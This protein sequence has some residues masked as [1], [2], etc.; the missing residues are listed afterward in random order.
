MAYDPETYIGKVI[1]VRSWTT[2][3]YTKSKINLVSYKS[4][5]KQWTTYAEYG[6]IENKI[7]GKQ[8][9]VPGYPRV[10]LSTIADLVD[11]IYTITYP[12]KDSWCY[13]ET[14]VSV[15]ACEP[16]TDTSSMLFNP[17]TS[18]VSNTSAID[19]ISSDYRYDAGTCFSCPNIADTTL[20]QTSN[21]IKLIDPFVSAKS[22]TL[23]LTWDHIFGKDSVWGGNVTYKY[24]LGSTAGGTQILPFTSNGN[25]SSIII[26]NAPRKLKKYSSSNTHL[27]IGSKYRWFRKFCYLC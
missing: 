20:S 15:H 1:G 8:L 2:S 14:N 24:A 12:G 19:L 4:R 13:F 27:F 10:E 26:T 9:Y 22:D 17:Y 18:D 3:D 11:G 7:I 25:K 16:C 23:F 21:N 5:T 6:T